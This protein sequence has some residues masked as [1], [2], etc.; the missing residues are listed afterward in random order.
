MVR[1]GKYKS[2]VEP[3]LENSMSD[4]NRLQIKELLQSLWNTMVADIAESRRVDIAHLNRIADE[5][6]ARNPQLA[7]P[8]G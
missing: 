7:L 1:H 2:A 6:N 5:L 8:L 4:D 3:Y